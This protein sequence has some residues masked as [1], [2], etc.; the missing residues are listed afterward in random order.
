MNA[1]AE[2]VEFCKF[3]NTYARLPDR[4]FARPRSTPVAA[5]RLVELNTKLALDLG[6]IRKNLRH[7]R[8]WKFLP[9][10]GCRWEATR[11]P[12]LMRATNLGLSS[13][14]SVMDVPFLLVK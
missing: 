4:F 13:L 1:Q 12:R 8:V 6:L 10:I 5:P 7:R 14:S 2:A 9:A 11:S 3:D